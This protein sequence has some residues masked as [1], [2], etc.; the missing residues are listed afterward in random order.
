MIIL[1]YDTKD[2]KPEQLQQAVQT[3]RD[4][5]EDNV[6]AVPKQ[7]DVLLNASLDQLM[8]VRTVIDT[9]MAE[10][11]KAQM[12]NNEPLPKVELEEESNIIKID[13]YLH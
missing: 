5:S 10:M 12:P 8:M 11:I 13:K 7:F 3:L 4:V 2:M 6:V 9:A 1:Y